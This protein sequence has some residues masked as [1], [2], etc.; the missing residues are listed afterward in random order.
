M[1]AGIS[2]AR[3]VA[4][5]ILGK[6]N[7]NQGN[8][9]ALLHSRAAMALSSADRNLCTTLVM[10]ALRWQNVLD[11]QFRPFLARP[12]QALPDEALLALRLGAYQLLFLDRI[13]V[14]AAIFESVEWLKHSSAARQAGMV[15]AVLRKVAA[16]PKPLHAAPEL[17]Y[18]EWL[19]TRWQQFYGAEMTRRI[20]EAGQQEPQTAVRLL[21]SQAE[22]GLLASNPDLQ[23]G[24]L[25]RAARRG[26]IAEDA[27][28]TGAQFQ[29]EGS[30]LVAEFLRNGKQI[31]DAC[32]APG[33]KTA[34]LAANN[35]GARIVACDVQASRLEA[36]RRR[37]DRSL[38]QARIEYRV[39]DAAALN[40]FGTFDRILCDVPCSGTGTLGRNPEI[41]H[42]L[43]P[44]DLQRQSARQQAI[45]TASLH[46]LAP[47]GQLLY[48]TCSLEPEEN[49]QVVDSVFEQMQPSL[50]LRK[51]D[52]REKFDQLQ[53][54]GIAQGEQVSHLQATGFCNGHLRT[55]LGVHPGDGFFA[56][57]IERGKD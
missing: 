10:G 36:M 25:L 27:L 29:D 24:A 33:G 23:P 16:L 11:A 47:G 54:Q 42:R 40:D 15:N 32:A 20:C 48:S 52:L 26:K 30:Q 9:D 12:N 18:P 46:R 41:R 38:P 7:R 5:E 2:P 21:T 28:P 53:Q 43:K 37:L 1:P 3:R 50:R 6:I 31:F 39:A 49:E 14:H 55:L 51:I 4:L 34:I 56:A 57:M 8:S 17:A 13:P 44:E 22:A 19:V 45:L 35:P